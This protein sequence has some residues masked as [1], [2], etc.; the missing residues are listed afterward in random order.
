V[1]P[2]DVDLIVRI[3]VGFTLAYLLGFERQL[4]GAAAGNRT[5]SMVGAAAAAV[6][7]VTA[8]SSPQAVAGV[9]TGV[10]F[11]GAGVVFHR[12]GGLIKGV[13]T[14][15]TI[16]AASAIGVV[17]GYGHLLVAA[18]TT[19]ILLLTLELQHIPVLRWLDASANRDRFDEDRR[20]PADED[21]RWD[22]DPNR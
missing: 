8:R 18:V 22:D 1:D 14:A 7:S 12:Q 16:F 10:G 3:A 13:T 5:F 9:V 6:T 21:H 11:I 20:E 17:V 4:R 19:A 15:A 2:T